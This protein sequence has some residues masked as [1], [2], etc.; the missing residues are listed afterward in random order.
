M[1]HLSTPRKGNNSRSSG[2][3]TGNSPN[4]MHL[5]G[6]RPL[7]IGCCR[8]LRPQTATSGGSDKLRG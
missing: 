4:P 5:M 8:A 7:C 1:K 6:R 3:R 2:E